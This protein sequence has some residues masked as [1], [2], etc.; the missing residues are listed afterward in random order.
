M[1][2]HLKILTLALLIFSILTALPACSSLQQRM[3]AY[4]ANKEE[5]YLNDD[6]VRQFSYQ[7]KSYTILEKN[8]SN[9]DLGDWVGYIRKF[10][11]V[12]S[13]GR[14]LLQETLGTDTLRTLADMGKKAPQAVSIIPFLNVYEGKEE[15]DTL[16]VDVNG[17]Y[18]KAVPTEKRRKNEKVLDFLNADKPSSDDFRIN[19]QNATELLCGDK[20]YEISTQKVKPSDLGDFLGI[21]AQSIT[22]DSQS[23]LP[24]SKSDLNKMD[25]KGESAD[26]KREHWTY[27][28][29]CEILDRKVEDAVA[30]NI[31]NDYYVAQRRN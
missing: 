14:I 15:S 30:V 5:C 9:D 26:K 25:W 8:C 3:D 10:A 16:I 17:G 1:K 4:A 31:N 18:H 7:K 28:D 22:F 19:P 24:L 2:Q 12:D 27:I 13:N 11:A 23:K 29:I 21:L 20:V 6:D